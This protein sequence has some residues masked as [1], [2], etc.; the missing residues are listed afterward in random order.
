MLRKPNVTLS[1]K[2]RTCKVTGSHL[3]PWSFN[4]QLNM[5]MDAGLLSIFKIKHNGE[6]SFSTAKSPSVHQEVSQLSCHIKIQYYDH[7]SLTPNS[8]HLRL[9]HHIN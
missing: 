1:C 9:L 8:K 5:M 7:M 3:N 2:T 6:E 4:K